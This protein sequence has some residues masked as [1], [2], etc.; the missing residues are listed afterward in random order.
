MIA[1]GVAHEKGL[2]V[3]IVEKMKKPCLKLGITGKGRCNLT[4]IENK[5]D[6]LEKF[7]TKGERFLKHSLYTF[8]QHNL[9]SFFNS[10]NIDLITERGGRVFPKSGKAL[11]IVGAL[12][13]WIKKKQIDIILNAQVT[14]L[15]LETN[16]VVGIEY[17]NNKERIKLTSESV[18]LATGGKS[19]PLTGSTGD[20]YLIAKNSGHNIE[21]IYPSLVPIETELDINIAGL[22]LR[23]IE[24][25]IILNNKCLY[26]EFGELLFMEY[27]V[28]GPV[29]LTMS[30]HIV[31]MINNKQ[32]IELSID[33][34]T[35]LTH[36]K[37]DNRLLREFNKSPKM[38][39]ENIL[40]KL[41][42]FELIETCLKMTKITKDKTGGQITAKER[43]Q[44]RLWL[45]DFR[46]K[47]TGYRP[48]EEAIITSGGI[49]LKE[50][51]SKTMESKIINNL[52]FAGEILDIDAKTGGYN[53][54][55]AFSTGY[56]AGISAALKK[57]I[58][59]I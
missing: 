29:I 28:S 54:Q 17:K 18:I 2:K 11:N 8:D 38:T 3:I 51:N 32:A 47:I 49:N 14:S 40:R 12:K 27:G 52:Y 53:I 24:A 4:N 1:A 21:K 45:K 56:L 34:K 31:E 39:I 9:I 13:D 41:L 23:N 25:S 37:L 46:I 59:N 42:P 20:G 44:I 36:K 10:L 19:Y 6:F 55:A 58:K 5:K 33:L 35:A 16:S 26:K 7:G 48:I 15:I 50:V 30:K 22:N 57:Q 43:K